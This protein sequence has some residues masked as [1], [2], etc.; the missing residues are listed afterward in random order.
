MRPLWKA[1]HRQFSTSTSAAFYADM[2]G[3]LYLQQAPQNTSYP[4]SV[5]SIVSHNH[6]WQFN[7]R[8]EDMLIQFNIFDD[9]NTSDIGKSYDDLNTMFDGVSLTT[10][11]YS[12]VY[13]NRVFPKS[14]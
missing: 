2:S 3:R 14:R 10:T 13:M 11:D 9:R 5:F 12:C 1:I 8:I 6:E 4:Y 7:D